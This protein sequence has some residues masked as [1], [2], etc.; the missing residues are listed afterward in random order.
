MAQTQ[1]NFPILP[2]ANDATSFYVSM[3]PKTSGITHQEYV[4]PKLIYNPSTNQFTLNG[5][6]ISKKQVTTSATA[7]LNPS[8]G[9]LWYDNTTDITFSYNFDGATY[10][11][12]DISSPFL[13]TNFIYGYI[14]PAPS[15]PSGIT[16]QYLI[17]AG[18]GGGGSGINGYGG[19]GGAGGL[20]QGS[21]SLNPGTYTITVGGGGIGAPKS[22]PAAIP[23]I[24][25]ANGNNSTII[26]S[27][28]GFS[29]ITAYGGGAG[30]FYI[31]PSQCSATN[32]FRAKGGGSA[33]GQGTLGCPN[34]PFVVALSGA[35]AIGSPG[36]NVAGTQGY[37]GG[38]QP[39]GPPYDAGGGGGAGGAGGPGAS[40]PTGRGGV[41]GAGYTWPFTANTYASGGA[42]GS[43]S[44]PPGTF[45]PAT[46]GG[47][48]A[49]GSAYPGGT[50]P[51]SG[52][53]G[54]DGTP[55]TGGGGGGAGAFGLT[56]LRGGTGGSGV[57]I[58]V[59]PTAAYPTVSAPGAIAT[60]P[61]AAPGATV[62][63]YNTPALSNTTYTFTV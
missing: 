8:V 58:L 54:G 49:G 63:T 34:P 15:G 13:P 61:P 51:A 45:T 24:A 18:G 5:R 17:V 2:A 7:P 56:T 25:S 60:T 36:Q 22:P 10:N 6:A 62:L 1:T 48:G 39:F 57:V 32:D 11:W 14:N 33:G 9:D 52:S 46:P 3:Q 42:G 28:P 50:G 29:T 43:A 38:N 37:P 4:S 30:G 44:V 21:I 47:G 40:A 53:L 27:T 55:G 41:G 35:L 12:V 23:S 26:S 16:V 20:L 59:I 19:G 31:G